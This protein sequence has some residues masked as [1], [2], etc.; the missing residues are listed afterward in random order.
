MGSN[1]GWWR[2]LLHCKGLGLNGGSLS[3]E[4]CLS[5]DLG[6]SL[7]T[8][9]LLLHKKHVRHPGAVSRVSGLLRVLAHISSD[10]RNKCGI[11]LLA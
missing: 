9:L 4:L 1:L 3:M 2:L 10:R 6:L 8:H 5:S 11:V 7:R